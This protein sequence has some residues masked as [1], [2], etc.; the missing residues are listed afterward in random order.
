MRDGDG[1]WVFSVIRA[2]LLEKRRSGDVYQCSGGKKVE[3]QT[4]KVLFPPNFFNQQARKMSG[5]T[6][7]FIFFMLPVPDYS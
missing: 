2:W 4:N 3:K 7:F 1:C 6:H 5:T